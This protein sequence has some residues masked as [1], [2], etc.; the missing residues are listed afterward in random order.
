M[1]IDGTF[2]RGEVSLANTE[3]T[4]VKE[5][6]EY[7]I[8]DREREI[9]TDFLGHEM[10]AEFMLGLS[11]TVIPKKWL[12]LLYGNGSTWGGLV[13]QPVESVGVTVGEPEAVTVVTT[14]VTLVV[15]ASMAGATLILSHN[16]VRY[17]EGV[18]FSV[19]GNTVTATTFS[20]VAGDVWAVMPTKTS[21][22]A[23]SYSRQSLIANFVYYHFLAANASQTTAIGQ[24]AT[25][26]ENAI[27]VNP[28]DKMVRA[29]NEMVNW[30]KELCAFLRANRSDYPNWKT[31]YC[32]HS[33]CGCGISSDK[34]HYKNTLDL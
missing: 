29:W 6:L 11:E 14:G 33:H 16:G 27:R 12:E 15:P 13:R 20:F 22:T 4:P 19:A 17:F 28:V 32:V 21:S 26:A 7:I 24:A 1:I 18:N 2:F 23:A 31:N 8:A 9:L 5:I 10:Y 34:Y 3:K 25:E 30:L